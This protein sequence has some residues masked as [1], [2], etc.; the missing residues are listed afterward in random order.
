MVAF[1]VYMLSSRFY[2]YYHKTYTFHKVAHHPH[3]IPYDGKGGLW[4]RACVMGSSWM[5]LLQP[6]L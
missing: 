6:Y 1:A 3:R 4:C 2:A 5:L